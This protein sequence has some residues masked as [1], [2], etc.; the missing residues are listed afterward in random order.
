MSYVTALRKREIQ[1]NLSRNVFKR[2]SLRS[3]SMQLDEQ[4]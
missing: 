4:L 1:L 3:F 2:L